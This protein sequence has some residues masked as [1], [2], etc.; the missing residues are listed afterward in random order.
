MSDRAARVEDHWRT[1]FVRKYATSVKLSFRSLANIVDSEADFL[2]KPLAIVGGNG[3]GKSTL[4]LAVAEVLAEENVKWSLGGRLNGSRLEARILS[5]KNDGGEIYQVIINDA[6]GVRIR[7]ASTEAI[8][9]EWLDAAQ[10]ATHCRSIASNDIGFNEALAAVTPSTLTVQERAE[11]VAVIGRSY[12]DCKIY[13]LDDYGGLER[14]PYFLVTS[15]GVSYGSERMGFGELCIFTIYWFI[16][17][18]PKDS[19]L[20]LEE[21]ETHISPRS[22]Q[23]LM[24][25]IAKWCVSH[26]ILVIVTTH[27]PAIV[28]NFPEN[29]IWLLVR[30]GDSTVLVN[31]ASR[32]DIEYLLGTGISVR[33]ALFVED[34]AARN[35]LEAL[36]WHLDRNLNALYE[37]SVVKSASQISELLSSIPKLGPWLSIVGVYDAD[38]KG[39]I[40]ASKFVWPYLYLPVSAS[41]DASMLSM[42]R[43][44]SA[45]LSSFLGV[46]Q[47]QLRTALEVNEGVNFHDWPREMAKILGIEMGHLWKGLVGMWLLNNENRLSALDFIANVRKAVES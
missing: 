35:F 15:G 22:Q 42:V 25:L 34:A 5:R 30:D 9:S 4:A 1:M 46:E 33:G 18:L 31:P 13:E 11:L 27:S 44:S 41:P 24:N 12:E 26:G 47:G 6:S 19:V 7:S 23:C 29:R 45:G 2:D 28:Q 14:F 20:I 10:L 21:P 3:V 36:L 37:I 40:D 38:Q 17:D 32:L 43:A 16:R 8:A 39:K